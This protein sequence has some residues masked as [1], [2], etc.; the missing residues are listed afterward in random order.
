MKWGNLASP[1]VHNKISSM[2]DTC[3]CEAMAQASSQ[4]ELFLSDAQLIHPYKCHYMTDAQ[5]AAE[6]IQDPLQAS[7]DYAQ[8]F[9]QCAFGTRIY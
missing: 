4:L 1:R 9:A 8:K 6:F 2:D 7:V 3:K 5:A